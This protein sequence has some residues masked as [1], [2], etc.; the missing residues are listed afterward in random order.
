LTVNKVQ[1][2]SKKREG[3]LIMTIQILIGIDD[4]D[5]LETH[6]TGRCARQLGERL[7]AGGL[8]EVDGITR[9]QLLIDPRI[10]YTSHNSSACLLARTTTDR[11]PDLIAAARAFLLRESAPGSDA[12]LCVADQ[13]QVTAAHQD[14]GQRAKREVLT[15]EQARDCAQRDGLT[16]EALTGTGGGIIGALAA[17]GLRAGGDDGRFLWLKGIREISGVYTVEQ[18][19]QTTPIDVVQTL[20]GA[21]LSPEDRVDLGPWIRPV[22]KAGRAVLFVEPA[23]GPHLWRVME[24]ERVKQLSS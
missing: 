22:L 12:G 23:D 16:L 11:L 18:L 7:A 14:F 2:N 10:P 13:S 15:M 17:V 8:A 1:L 5:N 24:K 21:E 4:T 3:S 9:H 6:G 19:Q 20:G